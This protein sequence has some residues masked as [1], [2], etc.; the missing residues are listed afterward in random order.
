[1]QSKIDS[2]SPLPAQ[3]PVPTVL[4]T[5]LSPNAGRYYRTKLCVRHMTGRCSRGEHCQFSHEQSELRPMPNLTKTSLCKAWKA[6]GSC[7][8]GEKCQYAHGPDELRATLDMFKKN[9]CFMWLRGKCKAGVYCRHAHGDRERFNYQTIALPVSPPKSCPTTKRGPGLF[10]SPDVTPRQL[11]AFFSSGS[12]QTVN[13]VTTLPPPGLGSYSEM[14]PQGY[15][16][17]N[18]YPVTPPMWGRQ[19][20]NAQ[21]VTADRQF[22]N[23]QSVTAVRHHLQSIGLPVADARQEV[24]CIQVEKVPEEKEKKGIWKTTQLEGVTANT[25]LLLAPE[26]DEIKAT[27]S[28]LSDSAFGL[29]PSFIR[30]EVCDLTELE[31][32]IHL[33]KHTE[34]VGKMTEMY[35]GEG[36][37]LLE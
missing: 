1:M 16:D 4:P 28:G 34:D 14:N 6:L 7:D 10:M 23:G 3:G 26:Q 30:D 22:R 8:K 20:R 5:V 13:S 24:P 32:E 11:V 17:L 29:L 19:L 15:T 31:A 18:Q 35:R 37:V 9:V 27:H 2:Q 12:N 25:C 36:L 21:S 33:H